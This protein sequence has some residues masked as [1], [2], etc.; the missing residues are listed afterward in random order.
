[1]AANA[2]HMNIV[3]KIKKTDYTNSTKSQ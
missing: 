1:L 3:D 2:G